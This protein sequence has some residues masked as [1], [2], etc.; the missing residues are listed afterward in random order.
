[1]LA[2]KIPKNIA[3]NNYFAY[4]NT[5]RKR[6]CLIFTYE[7]NQRQRGHA[8][9]PKRI[10]VILPTKK[11]LEAENPLFFPKKRASEAEN[12]LFFPG[13]ENPPTSTSWNWNLASPKQ[14]HHNIYEQ[15]TELTVG[16]Q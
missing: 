7:N 10:T 2:I 5:P 8:R 1:M 13:A 14:L 6:K 4:K 16:F 9:R 3:N 11:H 15:L 12:P